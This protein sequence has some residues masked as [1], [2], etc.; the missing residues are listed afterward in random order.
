MHKDISLCVEYALGSWKEMENLATNYHLVVT[1]DRT[2]IKRG[3]RTWLGQA[4]A[5]DMFS[6]WRAQWQAD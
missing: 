1:Y 3:N 6:G 4:A 2:R 5:M